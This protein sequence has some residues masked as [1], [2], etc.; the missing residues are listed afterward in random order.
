MGKNS[1][2]VIVLNKNKTYLFISL[3]YVLIDRYNHKVI[4]IYNAVHR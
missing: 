2:I 3:Q 4:S 1:K